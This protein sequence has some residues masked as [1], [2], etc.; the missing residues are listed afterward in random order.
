[1]RSEPNQQNAGCP[2]GAP[3]PE[4]VQVLGLLTLE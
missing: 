2:P 1:M 4:L 3:D